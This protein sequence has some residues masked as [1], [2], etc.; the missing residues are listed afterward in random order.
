[1][2]PPPLPPPL[3]CCCRHVAPKLPPPPPLLTPPNC[4]CHCQVAAAAVAT[5]PPRVTYQEYFVTYLGILRISRDLVMLK[6]NMSVKLIVISLES[7]CIKIKRQN[8]IF[9]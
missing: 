2:L 1:M 3:P 5:L 9:R 4:C 6:V 8:A 7:P